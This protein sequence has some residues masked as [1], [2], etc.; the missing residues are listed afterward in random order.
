MFNVVCSDLSTFLYFYL[1]LEHMDRIVRELDTST[2][3]KIDLVEG[4]DTSLTKPKL[5]PHM[6]CT[7]FFFSTDK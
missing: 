5:Q 3:E 2:K 6:L 1:I 4:G 7:R